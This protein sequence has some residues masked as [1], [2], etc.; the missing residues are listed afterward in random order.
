MLDIFAPKDISID[1]CLTMP[2]KLVQCIQTTDWLYLRDKLMPE[3]PKHMSVLATTVDVLL[4]MV[5]DMRDR[6]LNWK[7]SHC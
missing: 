3:T 2:A 6:D 1:R 5:Q 4:W 7:I